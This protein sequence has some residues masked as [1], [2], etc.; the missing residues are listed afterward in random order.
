MV[1][2]GGGGGGG[3]LAVVVTAVVVVVACGFSSILTDEIFGMRRLGV[4]VGMILV[5]LFGNVEKKD[6]EKAS[7]VMGEEGIEIP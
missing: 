7:M 5:L 4:S 6:E 1:V 3:C 2:V